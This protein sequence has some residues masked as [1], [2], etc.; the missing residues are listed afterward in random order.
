MST[1][2]K[3]TLD[4]LRQ[5]LPFITQYSNG[6]DRTRAMQEFRRLYAEDPVGFVYAYEAAMQTLART[7]PQEVVN[8]IEDCAGYELDNMPVSIEN[9]GTTSTLYAL[10]LFAYG[11]ANSPLRTEKITPQRAEALREML[12][13]HWFDEKACD[14]QVYEQ[15]MP[16]THRVVSD[17]PAAIR[18]LEAMTA[19]EAPFVKQITSL[20]MPGYDSD[21][22]DEDASDIA[23]RFRLILISVTTK[24]RSKRF[25]LKQPYTTPGFAMPVLDGMR[26]TP[27]Y[28][29][30]TPWGREF[31][32][33][34]QDFAGELRFYVTDPGLLSDTLSC[35][36]YVVGIKRVSL[37]Y[38]R[39]TLDEGV[40]ERT[41][42]VSFG[43]FSDPV[44]GYSEL[45]VAFA[46][47]DTPDELVGGVALPLP[48]TSP[49]TAG[50]D[51][52]RHIRLIIGLEGIITPD[53]ATYHYKVLVAEPESVD[54][55]FNTLTGKQV[56]IKKREHSFISSN[57]TLIFN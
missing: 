12:Y 47:P 2:N 31:S 24:K 40:A 11:L 13:K 15:L 16:L 41:L 50:D 7:I 14:I 4:K 39:A 35:L 10:G 53:P 45:R 33:W 20:D 19:E 21:Y 51:L 48:A 6:P 34:A 23:S 44:R 49:D 22:V 29:L 54:R 1:N 27:D 9:N 43:I 57:S 28:I 37:A 38:A 30:T 52:I 8:Q 18:F 56:P 5:I 26:Y 42:T 32:Q 17:T 36:D 25:C 3:A 55:L 46:R